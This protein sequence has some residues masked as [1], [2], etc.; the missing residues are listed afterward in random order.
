M[1]SLLRRL[2]QD[3]S[4]QAIIEYVLVLVIVV[5][6][7]LGGLYQ[8]NSAFR[9]WADSYFGDYLACLLESGE[10]PSLG[11]AAG[12]ECGQIFKPFSLADGRPLVATSSGPSRSGSESDR[13]G[14][15]ANGS[16][17]TV[18]TYSGGEG[19]AKTIKSTSGE[20]R[21]GVNSRRFRARGA[22]GEDDEEKT[23]TG[24]GQVT[25][26]GGYDSGKVVR[27]RLRRSEKI[28]GGGA[29]EQDELDKKDKTKAVGV[30]VEGG[31]KG[32]TQLINITRKPGS[33]NA[34][35]DIEE[36]TFGKL[37]RYLLIAAIIIAI[38]IFVGGQVLQVSKSME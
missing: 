33:M 24:S 4:G 28:R 30:T 3:D 16:A 9:S 8:L 5:G 38:I 12:G 37:F 23:N 22:G 15:G 14:A 31:E 10:L 11:A 1:R 18:A 26:L 32:G 7:I 29:G 6:I 34:A 19:G 2:R 25:E 21:A 36:F 27:I 13:A 35:P 17:S 20:G